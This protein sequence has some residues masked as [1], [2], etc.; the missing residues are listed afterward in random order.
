[1]KTP[2]PLLALAIGLALALTGPFSAAPLPAYMASEYL[3][4][5]P[6]LCEDDHCFDD[7][8]PT[9]DPPQEITRHILQHQ[10]TSPTCPTD[11]IWISLEYP[12]NT[13]SPTLD[14]RLA[15]S[16]D[17]LFKNYR[18][19]AEELSCNDFEGCQGYC[20]PVGFEIKQYVHK[21]SPDYL[22]IF[23]VERFLGNFRQNRHI[24]GTVNYRFENYTLQTGAP[25][26]L[27]DIFINPNAAVPRFWAKVAEL[28]SGN[29]SCALK[30]LRVNGRAISGRH[31]EPNDLIL[32]KGGATIALTARAPAPCRSQALDISVPDML[33]IGAYPALWEAD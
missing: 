21:P 16:M 20:L 18:N 29:K 26:R 25:L 10:H 19:K 5:F 7:G 12:G 9:S 30:N 17:N 2:A 6:G 27:K 8:T 23:R 33:E 24:R 14:A 31:L 3:G 1:M 13:G 28:V 22:S 32:T 11:L 4:G 15:K